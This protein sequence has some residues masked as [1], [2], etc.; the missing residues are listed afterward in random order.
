LSADD[1]DT[2]KWAADGL[3]YLTLDADVKEEF[4]NDLNAVQAMYTLTKVN[5]SEINAA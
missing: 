4:V 2:K 5:K 3:A 1:Y